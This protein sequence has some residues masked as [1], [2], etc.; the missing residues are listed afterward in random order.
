MELSLPKVAAG[1]RPAGT[2]CGSLAT[3]SVILVSICTLAGRAHGFPSVQLSMV[4]SFQNCKG[5]IL[6]KCPG[7][8]LL[9]SSMT[10]QGIM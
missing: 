2:G 10:S 4:F 3:T 7:V 1:H 9:D 6:L 5:E 8:F